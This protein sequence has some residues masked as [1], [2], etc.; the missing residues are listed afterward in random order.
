M[1]KLVSFMLQV[2]YHDKKK[3]FLMIMIY[4]FWCLQTS[5]YSYNVLQL[6]LGS[7]MTYKKQNTVPMM[8]SLAHRRLIITLI[9]NDT[10]LF[11]WPNITLFWGEGA[12]EQAVPG[13]IIL[14]LPL[15]LVHM[16]C[17]TQVQHSSLSL[18]NIYFV[19]F[20]PTFFSLSKSF[21]F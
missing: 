12:A 6:S 4:G 14:H 15:D 18:I 11:L 1:F 9:L 8:C 7:K 3:I 2:F 20:S 13:G 16:C 5:S 21:W 17:W 10:F 19:R